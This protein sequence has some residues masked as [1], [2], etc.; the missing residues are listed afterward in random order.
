M[1]KYAIIEISTK[2]KIICDTESIN[3]WIWTDEAYCFADVLNITS[4]WRH[5]DFILDI[6]V[7][8]WDQSIKLSLNGEFQLNLQYRLRYHNVAQ[9]QQVILQP[10]A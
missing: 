6:W 7:Q 3:M 10:S 8:I 4:S 5:K 9:K 2:K 1:K